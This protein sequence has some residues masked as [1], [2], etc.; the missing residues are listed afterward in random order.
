[1]CWVDLKMRI[2]TLTYA[3]AAVFALGLFMS[4]SA[5]ALE[6]SADEYAPDEYSPE[7][8]K[9]KMLKKLKEIG[10]GPLGLNNG[11]AGAKWGA[12]LA[13][14]SN[15]KLVEDLGASDYTDTNGL[16][17]NGH[18][19]LTLNGVSS[20]VLYRFAD[21][22]LAAVT[23]VYKGR[24][25]WAKLKQWVEEWY[26]PLERLG[27]NTARWDAKLQR[28]VNEVKPLTEMPT[29][30]GWSGELEWT[31]PDHG[32]SVRLLW[33][34]KTEEGGLSMISFVLDELYESVNTPTQGGD[35]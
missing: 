24:E 18:E 14:F 23:V 22:Q 29:D 33:N 15:M 8:Y 19:N 2:V 11:L 3:I 4:E 1:M 30:P 16:Y 9:P 12:P 5:G 35:C 21:E 28:Y 17:R 7:V 31:D 26:G 10:G 20:S 13:G 6:P 27:T 34:P 32:T 25:N